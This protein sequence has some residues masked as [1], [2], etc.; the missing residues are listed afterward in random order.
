[1][2]YITLLILETHIQGAEYNKINYSVIRLLKGKQYS[3]FI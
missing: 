1:M 3:Y 2:R